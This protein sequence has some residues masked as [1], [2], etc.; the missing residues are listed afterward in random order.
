MTKREKLI[1]FIQEMDYR[2]VVALHNE[3]C[4]K[5]NCFDDEIFTI[6]QLDELCNGQDAEWIANRVY[7]GDYNP[8]AEYLKFSA[9][10]NFQSIFNHELFDYIDENEIADYILENNDH[11]YNDDI[12]YILDDIEEDSD[13][14]C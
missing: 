10:G 3:Y 4:Y 7:F 6:D 11:L 13:D 8:S 14:E 2:D 5:T 1:D 12:L 9:Y